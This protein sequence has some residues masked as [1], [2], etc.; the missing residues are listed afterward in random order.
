MTKRIFSLSCGKKCKVFSQKNLRSDF[1]VSIDIYK[2]FTSSSL[3]FFEDS[4]LLAFFIYF[5]FTILLRFFTL[6]QFY[7]LTLFILFVRRDERSQH[8]R[9]STRWETHSNATKFSWRLIWEIFVWQTFIISFRKKKKKHKQ[10]KHWTRSA[11]RRAKREKMFTKRF[12]R[13]TKRERGKY[14]EISSA[15]CWIL[16]CDTML[17]L[18]CVSVSASWKTNCWYPNYVRQGRA[19]ERHRNDIPLGKLD[20]KNIYKSLINKVV[21]WLCNQYIWSISVNLNF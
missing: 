9:T 3:S 17:A 20:R 8:Q 1:D 14:P 7:Y 13:E 10:F 11:R 21:K 19:R 4:L 6:I 5:I 16:C 18:C 2:N 12:V 15:A